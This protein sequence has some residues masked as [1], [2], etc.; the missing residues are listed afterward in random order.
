MR[1]KGWALADQELAPGVR[2]VA[3]PVRDGDGAVLAA[4]NVTVHAAETSVE[5][6]LGEHLPL[7]LRAAGDISD[8]WALWQ[9]RPHVETSG[10]GTH[11]RGSLTSASDSIAEPSTSSRSK[12]TRL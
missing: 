6:L 11:R 5:R 1:A 10:R 9:T 12:K 7:L 8:D 4:M 3:A 2:S